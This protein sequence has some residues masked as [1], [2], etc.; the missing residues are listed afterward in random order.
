M[1]G[2]FGTNTRM[3]KARTAV[4]M[5]DLLV[6]EVMWC[7]RHGHPVLALRLHGTDRY[8]AVAMAADDASALASH[9]ATGTLTGRTR[10]YNL[11]E[12]T[13]AGLNGHIVEVQLF[14]D[15]NAILQ[16][17]VRIAAPGGEFTL[18]SHFADG[19]AL[20]HR[21]RIPLRMAEEDVSRIPAATVSPP[22]HHPE[23]ASSMSL[24]PF[25]D[26]IESLDLDEFGHPG[27]R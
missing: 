16:A 22:A 27:A 17:A 23:H 10:L 13:V 20:A 9:P 4:A 26:L 25:R 6:H 11:V 15:T 24:G 3:R 1:H 2:A 8:F 12:S 7:V 21:R 5:V 14:V 19:I 18:P